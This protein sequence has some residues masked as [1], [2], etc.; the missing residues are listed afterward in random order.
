MEV[1]L[2]DGRDT[3]I[4]GSIFARQVDRKQ[5]IR[6]NDL[7]KSMISTKVLR[8]V[9]F[10]LLRPNIQ[11][12]RFYRSPNHPPSPTYSPLQHKILSTALTLVPSSGFTQQ[13]L[14][15]AAK[16]SGYHEITHNLFPRG[17]WSI[18]EYHLE[19]QREKLSSIPLE[20]GRIGKNIRTLCVARLEGNKEIIQRWREVC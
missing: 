11:C 2:V 18:I 8:P 10:P 1:R 20:D 13:T 4:C 14:T 17:P 16:Q 19:T 7:H 5:K 6:S 3:E 15:E 12:S 9:S